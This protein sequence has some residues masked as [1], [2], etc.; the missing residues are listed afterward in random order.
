MPQSPYKIAA[1][2]GELVVGD[3]GRD[4]DQQ[5]RGGGDQRF[6]NARRD[7]A[8]RCR[9]LGAEAMEGIHDA[10]DGAEQADEGRDGADAGQPRQPLL[11]RRQGFAGRGLR[12]ALQRRDIAR[13]AIPARLPLVG[14][15]D[16]VKNVDQRAGL[17]LLAHRCNFL[18]PVGFPECTQEAAALGAGAPE[19]GPFTENDGP[20]KK[21]GG[22]QHHEHGD[23]DRS[24]GLEHLH[25]R[26]AVVHRRRSG[27]VRILEEK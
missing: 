27:R 11:H 22:E 9:A 12:R 4:G 17:E 26:A 14:L 19:A 3:H 10:H 5:S 23:G 18:Q 6:G 25:D 7:G 2:R 24:A 15:V 13:R 21:A 20:G 1:A 8:Q 16:L